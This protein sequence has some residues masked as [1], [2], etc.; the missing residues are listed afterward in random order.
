MAFELGHAAQRSYLNV[1]S[2]KRG[3][4]NGRGEAVDD[5][6]LT[7]ALRVALK[8]IPEPL[9]SP[10][11]EGGVELVW[12]DRDLYVELCRDGRVEMLSRKECVE[13]D[14]PT[15]AD[16]VATIVQ[17]VKQRLEAS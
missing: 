14:I 8:V 17:T 4:Y 11:V 3:W 7:L 13:I 6:L 10:T 12:A 5:T 16:K 1:R 9:F 15:G 2:L